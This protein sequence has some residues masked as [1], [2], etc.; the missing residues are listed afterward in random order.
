MRRATDSTGGG[1]RGSV[2]AAPL[3]PSK[4][5]S[6]NRYRDG[7]CSASVTD[8]A[9]VTRGYAI[10]RENLPFA[11]PAIQHDAKTGQ[12]N[13]SVVHLTVNPPS[14]GPVRFSC[15][16]PKT[17]TPSDVISALHSSRNGRWA[18]LFRLVQRAREIPDAA[19]RAPLSDEVKAFAAVELAPPSGGASMS[20]ST[21][22]RP[23]FDTGCFD[24]RGEFEWEL[25]D[26]WYSVE[27]DIEI[28]DDGDD[29]GDIFE[30][31]IDNGYDEAP[32]VVVDA[33]RYS[34]ADLDSVTFTAE[35]VSDVH[36]SADGWQWT[37]AE[38][39][40]SDP[41]TTAC[42]GT[43]TTCT[44]QI[45]GS[46]FMSYSVADGSLTDTVLVYGNLAPDIELDDDNGDAPSSAD[47]THGP[48][49]T[50]ALTA[51]EDSGV[52]NAAKA[53]GEWLYTQGCAR[54]TPPYVGVGTDTSQANYE[55]Q[56]NYSLRRG[57][58][59]DLVHYAHQTY[60]GLTAWPFEKMST[61]QFNGWGPTPLAKHG[62]SQIDSTQ[63]RYGDVVVKTQNGGSG[64]AG[65][66][67]GWG[68]HWQAQ[69][70]ANGGTPATLARKRHDGNTDLWTATRESGYTI[71]YFRAH[72]VAP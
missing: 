16:M 18:S 62:F 23:N 60:L 3:D 17:Q 63:V 12:G 9:G 7:G 46:G 32:H 47:S 37:P 70:W 44:I 43:A 45:H 56:V 25:D 19:H 64:H 42:I 59:T 2:N 48:T 30:Y 49:N 14:G 28:C 29:G 72:K 58:C 36:L 57:D 5:A 54:C 52:Y 51:Q 34:V 13:G 40:S 38:G 21:K 26:V 11:I 4:M 10:K 6:L 65:L 39:Y 22:L 15:W 24:V 8:A 31:L 41:W 55:E 33:N 20:K 61:S 69:A 68:A 53:S 66:F 71:K 67:K 1:L 35:V 27:V 50:V